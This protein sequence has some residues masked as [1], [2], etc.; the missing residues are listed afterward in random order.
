MLDLDIIVCFL[1]PQNYNHAEQSNLA[2]VQLPVSPFPEGVVNSDLSLP[3]KRVCQDFFS[4]PSMVKT[5]N[6]FIHIKGR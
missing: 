3:S 1:V 4:K 6:G 5:M 2:P